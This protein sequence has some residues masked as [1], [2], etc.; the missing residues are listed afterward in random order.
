MSSPVHRA[1]RTV[2]PPPRPDGPRVLQ[3]LALWA[4]IPTWSW[5]PRRLSVTPSV[6]S[7]PREEAALEP[8]PEGVTGPRPLCQ[9][10]PGHG[11][12]RQRPRCKAMCVDQ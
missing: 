6:R 1:W 8:S 11:G 5:G 9:G 10:S 12:W 2:S 7:G 4:H 3:A